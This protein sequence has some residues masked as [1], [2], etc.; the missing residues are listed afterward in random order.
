MR[1]TT[2]AP[3]LVLL[4]SQRGGEILQRQPHRRHALHVGHDE[5]FLG[6]AAEGVD[7][8]Q[9]GRALELRR[10][11]PVLHGAQ[12]GRLV[13]LADEVIAFGRDVA[14][15]GLQAGLAVA[16]TDLIQLA[17]LD[18]PHE[19]VAEP[20]GDRPHLGVHALGQVF[21]RGPQPLGDL[22]AREVD[23][24]L[25]SEDGRDLGEA[26]AAERAGI[27]EAGDAGERG[28]DRE[29]DL[30]LDLIGR[31]RRGDD[32][33]LHLVVGDVGNG[34]DRQLAQRADPEQCRGDGEKQ[35]EPALL[36]GEG[37]DASDHGSVLVPAFALAEFGLE[38][39]AVGGGDA[40]RAGQ[41]RT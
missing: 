39:E 2:P 41:A 22:L 10:D 1:L 16:V 34:V 31:E 4:R 35:D 27:F 23:V 12:V 5:I 13:G 14:A 20:G 9:P 3:A 19:D 6:V 29:G 25:F 26:V 21:L 15:V 37:D 18:G 8:G 7:A 11:D 33:D 32:V 40:L 17:V 28:L 30:L 38:R 36:D 24:G